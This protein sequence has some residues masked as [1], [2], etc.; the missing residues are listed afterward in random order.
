MQ[1]GGF[2]VDQESM[3]KLARLPSAVRDLAAAKQLSAGDIK[4]FLKVVSERF[5][6]NKNALS[7][8][9]ANKKIYEEHKQFLCAIKVALEGAFASVP[10]GLPAAE[11]AAQQF[12]P[13]REKDHFV[14]ARAVAS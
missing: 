3:S 8:N 2:G 13:R 9:V 6:W 1:M 10:A 14:T 5:D 7:A 11:R 12:Q 4:K